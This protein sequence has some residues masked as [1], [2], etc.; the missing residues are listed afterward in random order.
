M[1][2]EKGWKEGMDEGKGRKEWKEEL[3]DEKEGREVRREGKEVMEI[4]G[5]KGGKK[6][7]I[8]YRRTGR[9]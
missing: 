4:V 9:D 1:E 7:V 5:G 8:E 3:K 2:G 6:E